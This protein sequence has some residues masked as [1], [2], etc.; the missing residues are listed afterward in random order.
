MKKTITKILG[1]I[2]SFIIAIMLLPFGLV[3]LFISVF[4]KIFGTTIIVFIILMLMNCTFDECV[5]YSSS[6]GYFV[7]I[8]FKCREL[9][10]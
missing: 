5:K 6:L 8:Y 9:K 4:W 1:Y 2:L 7:G 10:K 3:Y